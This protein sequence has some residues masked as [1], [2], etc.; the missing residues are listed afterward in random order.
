MIPDYLKYRADRF[1]QSDIHLGPDLLRNFATK[2]YAVLRKKNISRHCH[3]N[4]IA[5]DSVTNN[6]V[7]LRTARVNYLQIHF[8]LVFARF[9][10]R[11]RIRYQRAVPFSV[12]VVYYNFSRIT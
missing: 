12:T 4:F 10:K 3:V 5:R 1:L 2:L 6:Y 11:F 9:M 8:G 7:K